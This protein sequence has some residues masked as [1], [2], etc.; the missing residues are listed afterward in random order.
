MESRTSE[1][2]PLQIGRT[3]LAACRLLIELGM[4][5]HEALTAVRAARPGAIET[6]AQQRYVLDRECE[7]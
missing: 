6:L 5:P 1:S 3:G 2:R 4:A 7:R